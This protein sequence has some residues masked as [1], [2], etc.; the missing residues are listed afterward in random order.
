MKEYVVK[1]DVLQKV[2]TYLANRPYAEVFDIVT[3]IQ[4]TSRELPGSALEATDS[5]G[6]TGD[7]GS[8]GQTQEAASA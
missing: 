4:T 5:S 1:G 6:A 2:L 3:S 8:T 7:Q